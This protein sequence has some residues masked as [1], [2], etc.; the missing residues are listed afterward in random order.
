MKMLAFETINII[1]NY[2]NNRSSIDTILGS[3]L[4]EAAIIIQPDYSHIKIR[5][6]NV[7][8]IRPNKIF[9]LN[10]NFRLRV[11]CKISRSLFCRVSQSALLPLLSI[12]SRRLSEIFYA[13][14]RLFAP[15]EF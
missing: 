7:Y 13:K 10:R 3:C 14:T 2:I 11:S 4:F 6:F 15:T 12:F 8:N 5:N 1:R 9:D